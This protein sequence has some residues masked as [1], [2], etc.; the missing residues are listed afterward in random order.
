M[1]IVLDESAYTGLDLLNP[2]QPGLR[3]GRHPPR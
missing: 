2:E 3:Q 1:H